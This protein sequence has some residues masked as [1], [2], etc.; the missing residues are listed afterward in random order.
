[1]SIIALPFVGFLIGIL[2]IS[3]GG[4]GGGLYVGI[5]TA[6]FAVPPAVAAATS[7]AT[8]IPTTA[9]GSFSHWKA[10]N[11]NVRLGAIMMGG[12]VLGAVAG[13]AA[14]GYVPSYF[15]N[16]I[17]GGLLLILGVQMLLAYGRKSKTKKP[18]L[19]QVQVTGSGRCRAIFYGF[20]GGFMSGMV[21]VSGT[22]PII[23]GLTVLGCGGL[24]TVG[25]SVFVLVGISMTGFLMH[26]G[27]GNVD[28]SLVASLILGTT[29][30]AFLGPVVLQHLSRE[31]LEKILPPLLIVLVLG[32]GGIVFFK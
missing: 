16:K 7:L 23:A 20:L 17:T 21:G 13:S 27:L 12:A 30:G 10:G 5:L 22:T 31:R 29:L 3:L 26:L 9:I 24:E 19:Q 14:S 28:W 1:M 4:G 8:I 2:L 32:M 15:Y 25:T 11:V 6:F 18:R